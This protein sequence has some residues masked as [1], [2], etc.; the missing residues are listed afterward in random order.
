MKQ[1]TKNCIAC[2][3]PFSK[4]EREGS[5]WLTRKYCSRQCSNLDTRTLEIRNKI[6]LTCKKNGV[7][8]WMQ[9]RERPIELRVRH[10][11][12]MK[13]WVSSGTHNFWKGGISELTRTFRSNFQNTVDYRI[14]RDSVFKRDNHTCKE[15]GARNGN[16]KRV[17]LN[18]DH[19]KS[20]AQ[21]PELRL[22]IDNGRTLCREC[23]YKRHSKVGLPSEATQI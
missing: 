10:S 21:Y 13:K 8:K 12:A 3:N 5:D 17:V 20:F 15:C 23:H 14:W 2:K 19:I 4:G 9:G 6:S 16:G 22:A 11:I 1:E 18:A 7:G